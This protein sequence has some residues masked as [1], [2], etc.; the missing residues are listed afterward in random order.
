MTLSQSALQSY[1]IKRCGSRRAVV[2]L[3]IL[4]YYLTC[5]SAAMGTHY[6]ITLFTFH[7]SKYVMNV[8]F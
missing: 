1:V 6:F 7:N 5:L 3:L 2:S 4:S 8:G